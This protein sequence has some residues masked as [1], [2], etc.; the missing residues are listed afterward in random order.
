MLELGGEEFSIVLV[1]A[2]LLALWPV[3]PA[4]II[5]Y[6]QRSLVARHIRPEF[7]LR[8]FETAELDRAVM[9]H[10]D[11]C[12]RL[13]ELRNQGEREV[14]FW[15]ALVERR[16]ETPQQY[17]DE[18]EDLETHAQLLQATIVRL[19]RRPLQRLKWWLHI[20]SSEFALGRAVA[21][22]AV[23]MVLLLI[24]A[25]HSFEQSA[26][27]DEL[28]SDASNRLIW[29]PFDGRFFYAN[30]VA[31]GFSALAAP[32]FYIVRW[33]SLCRRHSL[34][35]YAFRDLAKDEP[36][37][38]FDQSER[39]VPVQ[40]QLR[41]SCRDE[42]CEDLSWYTILGLSQ[43]ATIEEVRKAYK[44]LIKKNHPDR[45][46]DMSPAFRTLAES[47]TKKVNEAYR[48]ALSFTSAS[49]ERCV[50]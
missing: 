21:T 43:T 16:T 44:D 47:E 14:G 33:L 7:S 23:S 5:A 28:T 27:A 34:E 1:N 24:I 11:V 6:I 32:M 36:D 49:R 31:A 19:R 8:K 17:A 48:Q 26:F 46:H 25:F 50:V 39:E 30:A 35:F 2:V 40:E 18:L 22:H 10:H 41:Q 13:K 45:V 42:I 3:L 38:S 37:Q 9:L 4:L 20:K 12:C 29:Y 15:R